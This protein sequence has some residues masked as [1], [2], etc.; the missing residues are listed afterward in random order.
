[1]KTRFDICAEVVWFN[2]AARK[3]DTGEVKGIQIV[4]T[5]ISKDEAG[6]DRLDGYEVLYKLDS[7]L[8]LAE[9]EV[10]ASEAEARESYVRFFTG[11]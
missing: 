2:T 9:S 1:M 8:V 10:F 5:G 7:G 6:K 4:P 3:F 11:S